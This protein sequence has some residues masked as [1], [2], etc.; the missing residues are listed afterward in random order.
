MN[1]FTDFGLLPSIL[2]TLKEKQ[3]TKPTE[4]QANAIPL[5]MSGQ[6]VVGVSET[7]SGK[8]LAYVLPLLH[9]LKTLEE[10]GEPIENEAAPRA[11][12]MVP[13]RELGEQVSKV[14]KTLTHDTRLRVRP[15]LGGM[16]FEQARRN[17]SGPFEILLATPGRLVQMIEK[18]LIDL[19]D[20][21]LLIF[22]EADQMLD[23]GFLPDSNIIVDACGRGT[24][25]ALFS[26]TI[27]QAVQALIND[28][29]SKAEVIRSKGSGKVVSSLVTKNIVV[30]DGKRWPLFERILSQ[31]VDGGT[32]VFTNTRE[33]CDKLAKELTDKGFS[34]AIYRG[35]MDKNERRAN[36]KKFRDG[37]ID[38]LVSTDLA[39][40]GL[41]IDNVGR[42]INFHLPKEMENYL[43]R[44]G[45][46]ARAGRKGIVVNLVTERDQRLIARLGGEKLPAFAKRPTT[47]DT[48]PTYQK[49]PAGFEKKSAAPFAKQSASFKK[50]TATPIENKTAK[51]TAKKSPGFKKKPAPVEKELGLGK[52]R[53][54][55]PGRVV[56]S[57]LK[58]KR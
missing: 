55:L 41:D 24:Q 29:F 14:F 46:T 33:Q 50:K 38:L 45:R 12:V 19:K 23:Q 15:A 5:M 11:V 7:G 28:L 51:V 9:H 47:D 13:T 57:R 31:K 43:H 32:L 34:C 6:S 40:R 52:P 25:L 54:R 37:K 56:D 21:R 22:D 10:Q 26:A 2:K 16:T 4:I 58:Y 20:V 27:S 1:S 35:E 8:T 44:A 53:V 39:G 30:D 49:K 42:V 3:L 48:K 18:E 17:I 36:L